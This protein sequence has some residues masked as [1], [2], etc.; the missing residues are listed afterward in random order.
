MKTISAIIAASVL[1]STAAYAG[2]PTYWDNPMPR[3]D[4][5][6]ILTTAQINWALKARGEPPLGS[7]RV[8]HDDNAGVARSTST[9]THI[10]GS[11][12]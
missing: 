12:R 2:E 6:G 1:L 5:S 7:S 10:H 8:L 3:G 4:G 9:I 11:A